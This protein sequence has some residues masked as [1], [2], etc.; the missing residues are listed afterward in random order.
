MVG[1]PWEFRS[2]WFW[3]NGLMELRVASSMVEG[4]FYGGLADAMIGLNFSFVFLFAEL[5]F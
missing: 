5:S 2:W 3:G 1:G 4:D